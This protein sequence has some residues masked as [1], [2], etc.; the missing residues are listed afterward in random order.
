[1]SAMCEDALGCIGFLPGR[2]SRLG[3][4]PSRA[5]MSHFALDA[6]INPHTHT[7]THTHTRA[8]YIWRRENNKNTTRTQDKTGKHRTIQDN[9][10]GT[11][12]AMSAQYPEPTPPNKHVS[13][14]HTPSPCTRNTNKESHRHTCAKQT[15]GMHT[16]CIHK[17]EHH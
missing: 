4:D 15:W 2:E 10:Q 13:I 14:A 1:M 12:R 16:Q 7:H 11:D 5:Q 6:H 17:Q 9:V 3:I 8:Q